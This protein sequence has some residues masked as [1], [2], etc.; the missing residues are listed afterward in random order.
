MAMKMFMNASPDYD[1][2]SIA[3]N[4][5]AVVSVFTYDKTDDD[6]VESPVTILYGATGTSWEVKESYLEVV[7]R[8]NEPN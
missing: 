2:K 5:D 8:L 6:G 4:P 1:G 3:I 7:A